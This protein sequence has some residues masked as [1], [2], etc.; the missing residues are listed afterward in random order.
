[1]IRITYQ[2]RNGDIIKREVS[3]ITTH[4]IGETTSMGWKILNIQYKYNGK[5]YSSSD[6]DKKVDYFWKLQMKIIAFKRNIGVFR[7][8]L[9]NFFFLFLLFKYLKGSL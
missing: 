1:M 6:Y 2:K 8:Y 5:W 3:C 4:K 9:G 7:K